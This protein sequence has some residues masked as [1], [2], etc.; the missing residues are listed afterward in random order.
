MAKCMAKCILSHDCFMLFHSN[1]ARQAS[2]FSNFQECLQ[3][4]VGDFAR[5]A[6]MPYDFGVL[7]NFMANSFGGKA[8]R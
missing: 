5:G 1:A 8:G 6:A 7:S 2:M 4:S 3:W